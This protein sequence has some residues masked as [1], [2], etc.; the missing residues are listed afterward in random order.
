MSRPR[1][2]TRKVS[3][4]T[5]NDW[6]LLESNSKMDELWQTTTSKRKAPCTWFFGEYFGTLHNSRCEVEIDIGKVAVW[7]RQWCIEQGAEYA[8]DFYT[9][10][11]EESLNPRSRFWLPRPTA[12]DKFAESATL[13][14]LLVLPTA[15][16]ES[17]DTLLN[18][19]WRRSSSSGVQHYAPFL[20]FLWEAFDRV[21]SLC[22][23]F[24]MSRSLHFKRWGKGE[25]V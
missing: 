18:C 10:S 25:E 15:V 4:P 11:V 9:D 2:K 1:S 13:D 3:L 23:P 6:S 16:R 5:N 17:V 22:L 7:V 19:E 24:N 12:T 8:L 14:F 21:S 20:S